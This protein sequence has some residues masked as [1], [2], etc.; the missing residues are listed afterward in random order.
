MSYLDDMSSRIRWPRRRRA[1][2][3]VAVAASQ[4]TLNVPFMMVQWPGN[5]HT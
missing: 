5:V 4:D 1:T 3:G 2:R